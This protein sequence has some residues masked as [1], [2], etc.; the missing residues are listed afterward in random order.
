VSVTVRPATSVI[1]CVAGPV[2]VEAAGDA[3]VD[4]GALP[5]VGGADG[6]GAA[7]DVGALPTA[8]GVDGAGALLPPHA[9]RARARISA[10]ALRWYFRSIVRALAST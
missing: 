6:A 7:V 10:S 5:T 3:A 4:V 8:G 2:A 1:V 9:L